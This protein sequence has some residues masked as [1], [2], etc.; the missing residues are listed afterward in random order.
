MPL[1]VDSCYKD[2]VA[3]LKL[4]GE[5]TIRLHEAGDVDPELEKGAI[6]ES[7]HW[8]THSLRR[9]PTRSLVTHSAYWWRRE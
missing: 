6:L 1:Q 9:A 4:A 8:F 2:M 7:Y 3:A 5:A